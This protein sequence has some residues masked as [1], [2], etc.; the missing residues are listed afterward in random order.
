MAKDNNKQV[1]KTSVDG[2]KEVMEQPS[3]KQQFQNAL[4]ENS[5]MF[6][7]SLIDLYGSDG[8]MQ[9]CSP[10]EVVREAL[11][12]ATLKLPI[13]KS[14]GFAY[15][16]PYK[17]KNQA[18]PQFQI[19]YRGYIQ[20]AMRTGQYRY[21]NSDAVYEG[22]L[23]SQDKLTG[24]IDLSGDATSDK[25]IGYF[26]MIETV[27]GFRKVIYKTVNQI[28]AHAKQ[29]SKAYQYD[30]RS[31]KESSP[32]STNFDA[33]AKKTLL[34]ELLGKYGIMSVDMVSAFAKEED[35][36]AS[37]EQEFDWETDQNANQGDVMD[38]EPEPEQEDT[39]PATE[40]P[41]EKSGQ[42]KDATE[43]GEEMPDPG[44]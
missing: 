31:K 43:E 5:G 33:M 23:V 25:V 18:H 40:P 27:N 28:E 19:G 6:V 41:P 11:K 34:R 20:L 36:G 37:T 21:I 13:N 29:Y 39:V 26:A 22:E 42:A 17:S 44:F 32:W 10:G 2:L 8:M 3:V 9:Q 16:V 38:V 30:L 24:E 4:G 14:M 12:A 35:T 15:L 7:A 1:A